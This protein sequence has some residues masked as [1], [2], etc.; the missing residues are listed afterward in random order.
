[1]SMQS[2]ILAE[3]NEMAT[4]ARVTQNKIFMVEML[5]RS[6]KQEVANETYGFIGLV[7]FYIP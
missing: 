2:Q 4:R 6:S 7:V 5:V 3:A 1:L